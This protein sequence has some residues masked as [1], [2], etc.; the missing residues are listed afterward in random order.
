MAATTVW[1]MP[2]TTWPGLALSAIP[3]PSS[4]PRPCGSSVTAMAAPCA[5]SPTASSPCSLPCSVTKPSTTQPGL[6]PPTP[7]PHD[8]KPPSTNGGESE[9]T[10]GRSLAPRERARIDVLA[11]RFP[12]AFAFGQAFDGGSQLSFPVKG[13]HQDAVGADDDCRVAHAGSQDGGVREDEIAV[14]I[15][16]APDLAHRPPAPHV[17]PPR[18]QRHSPHAGGFL[19]DCVVNGHRGHFRVGAARCFVVAFAQPAAVAL[20]L[21]HERARNPASLG[22]KAGGTE[23]EDPGVPEVAGANECLRLL[24]RGFFDEPDRLHSFSPACG[25]L[26]VSVVCFRPAGR[27]GEDYG[28][29]RF[30]DPRRER[31]QPAERL[32]VGKR[33]V[34]RNGGGHR[35]AVALE[36][37]GRGEK[38]RPGVAPAGLEDDAVR[39]Q[40]LEL[41]ENQVSMLLR[42]GHE[43][44]F[45][46]WEEPLE[47]LGEKTLLREKRQEL[48]GTLFARER[49]QPRPASAGQQECP[50]R[51]STRG[52]GPGSRSNF[53]LVFTPIS[54]PIVRPPEQG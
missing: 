2:F 32:I 3:G 50:H 26:Q 54:T 15:G 33:L 17:A 35:V 31:Q 21:L 47:G 29:R 51:I 27:S 41:R 23:N 45:G 52:L 5:A 25:E 24:A 28:G 1:A 18:P 37:K 44:V 12:G 20:D 7:S 4:T 16:S 39:R 11:V 22:E 8:S 19:H 13:K 9:V 34:R 30:G 36:L 48:L 43:D 10:E 40:S 38:R 46:Q 53:I 14:F 42:G 6:M 49:P